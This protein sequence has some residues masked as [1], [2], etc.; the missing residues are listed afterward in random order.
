MGPHRHKNRGRQLPAYCVCSR[1]GAAMRHV[2][3]V[4]CNS[5]KCPQC[6][7]ATYKSYEEVAVAKIIKIQEEEAEDFEIHEI[8]RSTKYPVVQPELCS[9]CGNCI[10]ICPADCISFVEGTAFVNE[11]DCRNCKLCVT[12]CPENA[13]KI[14]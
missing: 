8:Q 3:G 2:P 11:S 12:A 6:G 7:H 13:F 9:A 5:R 1:C 4:P 10:D 14:K